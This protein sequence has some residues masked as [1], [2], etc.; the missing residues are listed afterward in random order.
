LI[1]AFIEIAREKTRLQ[2][3]TASPPPP[4]GEAAGNK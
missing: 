4:V 3:E 2:T 1:E